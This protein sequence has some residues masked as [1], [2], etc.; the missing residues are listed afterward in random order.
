MFHSCIVFLIKRIKICQKKE[1][2]IIQKANEKNPRFKQK[3]VIKAGFKKYR[4]LY[5]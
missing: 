3:F 1:N 2:K 4:S 5:T